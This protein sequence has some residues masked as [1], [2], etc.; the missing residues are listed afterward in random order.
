M[1][2]QVSLTQDQQQ[3]PEERSGSVELE[4]QPEILSSID[5]NSD[6]YRIRNIRS[7]QEERSSKSIPLDTS[8]QVHIIA[9]TTQKDTLVERPSSSLQQESPAQTDTHT[10][11][12]ITGS[13]KLPEE[14]DKSRKRGEGAS[15]TAKHPTV[16]IIFRTRNK[17]GD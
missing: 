5:Q 3:A 16:T 11:I 13:D 12:E 9:D 2:S 7:E 15:N 6:H 10:R 1:A 4:P 14:Q 17:H 8:P